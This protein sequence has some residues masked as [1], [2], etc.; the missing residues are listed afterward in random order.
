LAFGQDFG[1]LVIVGGIALLSVSRRQIR[2]GVEVATS[3]V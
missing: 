2:A 3:H 1:G